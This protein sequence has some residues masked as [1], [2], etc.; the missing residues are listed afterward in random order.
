MLF[1]LMKLCAVTGSRPMILTPCPYDPITTGSRQTAQIIGISEHL[2]EMNKAFRT[3]MP[4]GTE[5]TPELETQ[6]VRV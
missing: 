6:W 1:N 2:A 3:V 4:Y 5:P